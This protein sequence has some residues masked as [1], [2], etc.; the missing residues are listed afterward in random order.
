MKISI[1]IPQARPRKVDDRRESSKQR[2]METS[3]SP[4]SSSPGV[5]PVSL[6]HCIEELLKFLF[7]AS[8]NETL[9]I[10]LGLSKAYCSSLLSPKPGDCGELDAEDAVAVCGGFPAHPL[11]KHL[12][13]ALYSCITSG[14]F[15]KTCNLN[16]PIQENESLKKKEI[17]WSKLIASEGAEL[18]KMLEVA[19]FELHVQ[20]PFFNQLLG[21]TFAKIS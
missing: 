9:G 2:L 8:S 14:T 16:M 15:V 17:E 13:S 10:D 18:V 3:A 20:E 21:N 5:S 11:Y 6:S 7:A 1:F 4:S 19:D 12:A